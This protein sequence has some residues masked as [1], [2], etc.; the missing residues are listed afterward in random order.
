MDLSHLNPPQRQAV[1]HGELPLLVLAG[2][3]TGKTS[4]ITHRIAHFVHERAVYPERL[5]AVTFTNKAAREMRER[6]AKLCRVQG[7]GS[8]I[9]TF[10]SIC[11]RLLRR[12][13]SRLGL[14][15]N[16]LIYDQDD[17]LQLIKRCMVDLNV[18]QQAFAPRAVRGR[19]EEWKNRGQTP[20]EVRLAGIG[21]PLA[22]RALDIYRLYR[23]RCIEAN[24]VDFGDLLLHAVTLLQHDPEVRAGLQSRWTHV[25]VDEYQDTNPVQY[26]LLKLLV[27]EAH[28]LTVVGD[29]DQSIYRWRGADIGNILRFERDFPGAEVIRLE[30]N[31][32]ST[33]TILAAAN[34]VIANNTA[35]KGKTLFTHGAEG[36][37]LRLRVFDTE[38]DEGD[39]LAQAIG[40]LLHEGAAPSD[41][42]VLYR[43]NAQSRALEEALRRRRIPYVIFG[44]VRFYDRKEVKDALAYLR[45]L[46]NP[47]ST[48]DFLRVVNVPP[49]GIGKTTLEKL[50]DIAADGGVS[51]CEAA[52]RGD[53]EL[54]GRARTALQGFVSSL[55]GW[56]RAAAAGEHLGRLLERCLQESGY[57]VQLRQEGT[58]EA[59]D[60]LDNLAELV[61]ALDEYVDLSEETP[62]LA[63]FLEDVA[64]ATDI[65]GLGLE[66]GQVTLM[67]LHAAK[68]LEF[69]HVFLPGMEEG[70]FPHSRSLDDRAA[71]EE[72]RR[73]AYVGITRA[74]D[75]LM[76]SA[77]RVRSVFGQPQANLLSR[78]VSEIPLELLDTGPAGA[79]AGSRR[80]LETTSTRLGPRIIGGTGGLGPVADAD[81]MPTDLPTVRDDSDAFSPGT[82]VLH[83]T[84]GEGKVMECEGA[85]T[86]QKLIIQF[87]SVGKKVIV[88][89]FVERL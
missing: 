7:R 5:L 6:T 22:K 23:K 55:D 45:L 34:A 41:I 84:F 58:D 73:L 10:H 89:R 67:T 18:D 72:E 25:L 14:D 24:A 32:R 76:L 8:D 62:S 13:G 29:D 74:K 3:G 78:F 51:L 87:G 39:A 46:I 35:R 50:G 54:T 63:G 69:G 52:R 70:L 20:D 9:G 12:Y 30:Q 36:A 2:A 21:D 77:A 4:V 86:R 75:S 17:A 85:G 16:F 43:T 47:R 1:L 19:L 88:A 11:G 82:R 49:R 44:G 80:A 37:V 59:R 33:K 15:A 60:R 61:A 40:Q 71:L 65:D 57:L 42:A 79:S 83:A 48:I 26:L 64:L 56:A 53:P 66:Q 38:R 31:Y 81:Y 68:G 28:S 27:T